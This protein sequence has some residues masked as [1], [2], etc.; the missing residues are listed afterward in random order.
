MSLLIHQIDIDHKNSCVMF[1]DC[2]STF[3]PLRPKLAAYSLVELMVGMFVLAMLGLG[4]TK[5][6]LFS[7]ATAEDN[8]YEATALTVAISTMEQMQ[9][10]SLKLLKDPP[11]IGGAAVFEMVVAGNTEQNIFLGEANFL[12]VPIVTDSAGSIAKTMPLTLTPQIA[13]MENG[14]G[15][16]L[17]VKYSY[18]HPRHQRT[19]TQI[20]RS[21]RSTVPSG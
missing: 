9:G 6:L 20:M 14:M 19:R 13:P 3:P 11:T 7:K 5:A 17:S 21:A 4:M 2:K 12:E 18:D 8:L 1:L 15:Y 10:A 16:W